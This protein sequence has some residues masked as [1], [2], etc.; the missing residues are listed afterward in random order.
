VQDPHASEPGDVHLHGYVLGQVSVDLGLLGWM[1]SGVDCGSEVVESFVSDFVDHLNLI[2]IIN[3]GVF[4][5]SNKYE[6]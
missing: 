3:N 2:I 1:H 4:I 6:I 5:L